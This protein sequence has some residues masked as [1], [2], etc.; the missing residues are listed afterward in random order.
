LRYIELVFWIFRIYASVNLSIF[1]Y[2]FVI[3]ATSNYEF[4]TILLLS[5]NI[6]LCI[7]FTISRT[8]FC[9]ELSIL[10]STSFATSWS[11]FS[12]TSNKEN[13]NNVSVSLRKEVK[14]RD[15][16]NVSLK[17]KIKKNNVVKVDLKD[18]IKEHDN[19]KINLRNEVKK[20]DDVKV[21]S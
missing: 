3:I 5:L 14:K 2:S 11:K 7:L 8:I 20:S 13:R 21:N 19:V 10:F 15:K 12:I 17:M 1:V 18:K 6:L 4:V 9:N 16:V